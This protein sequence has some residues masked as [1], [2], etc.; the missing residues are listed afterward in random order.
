MSS[1]NIFLKSPKV[2]NYDLHKIGRNKYDNVKLSSRLFQKATVNPNDKN[3]FL[4]HNVNNK[5]TDQP[6]LPKCSPFV[7]WKPLNGFFCK[8]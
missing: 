3:I 8:Q 4:C 2:S 5:G 6:A 7:Y 1:K